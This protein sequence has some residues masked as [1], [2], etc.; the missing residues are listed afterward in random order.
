MPTDDNEHMHVQSTKKVSRMME[1]NSNQAA[2]RVSRL[3][4]Q[5]K[6]GLTYLTQHD[7]VVY[8]QSKKQASKEFNE[9]FAGDGVKQIDRFQCVLADCLPRSPSQAL[10]AQW[11]ILGMSQS[12]LHSFI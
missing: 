2:L 5:I 6:K 8:S 12:L 4:R 3:V 10:T 1:W 9:S 11:L 7:T